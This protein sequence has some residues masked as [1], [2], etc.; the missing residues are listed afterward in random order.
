MKIA[1]FG[2]TGMLGKALMAEAEAKGHEVIALGHNQCSIEDP[3]AVNVALDRY[4]PEVLI[5]AAG[6]IAAYGREAP[7]AAVMVRANA[8]GP[9]VLASEAIKRGLPLLHISTDCVFSGIGDDWHHITDRPDPIDLYGRSKLTGES[10][11]HLSPN[12]ITVVRTS[13]IGFDHGLLP[14]FLNE[15][16]QGRSVHGYR[17][18]YWNGST[19]Y[20]VAEN[21]IGMVEKGLPGGLRHLASIAPTSKYEVLQLL[22]RVF[23]LDIEIEPVNEP[24]I[25]RALAPTDR[26][27]GMSAAF[28]QLPRLQPKEPARA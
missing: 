6:V 4:Q 25:G 27:P 8:V 12:L 11:V 23:G 28:E 2:A 1:V 15:A 13:F 18:A 17:Q 24:V 5:N 20:H 22:R 26:L 16:A 7:D 3:A 9:H 14:W 21:L 19:V 10:I